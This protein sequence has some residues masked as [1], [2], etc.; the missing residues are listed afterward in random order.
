MSRK[1]KIVVP[2]RALTIRPVWADAILAEKKEIEFR[3][4]QPSVQL[5]VLHAG[6]TDQSADLKRHVEL[7]G[8]TNPERVRSAY[9]A[10]IEVVKVLDPS[11]V[12][13]LVKRRDIPDTFGW[14]LKVL[15]KI[16]EPIPAQGQLGLWRVPD[17]D[18]TRIERAVF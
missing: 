3:S 15:A 1:K 13:K 12:R 17:D 8:P 14:Q 9:T 11:Q 2:V 6:K 4:W 16:E 7:Y 18:L 5:F 10:I